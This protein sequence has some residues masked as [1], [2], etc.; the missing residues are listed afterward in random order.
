LRDYLRI[1]ASAVYKF[2]ISERFRSEIGAS[3]W[4]ISNRENVIN[5]FFRVNESGGADQFSRF[6]LGLTSNMV[7][8]IYF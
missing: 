7:F 3:L 5:N 6:S 8:R 2:K 4:N 1:D